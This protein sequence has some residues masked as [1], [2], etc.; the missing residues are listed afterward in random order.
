MWLRIRNKMIK[1]SSTILVRNNKDTI[2]KTINSI[3][4]FVDEIIIID[5][6]STDNTI[7]LI[8]FLTNK[9][10]IYQRKL[11]NDF[12]AQRNF[13]L[14]KCSND[15]IIVID[16][17]EEITDE[18]KENLL[19]VLKNPKY[20]AYNCQ[21]LNE[22][23]A[24]YSPSKLD[25]PILMKKDLQWKDAIHEVISEEMGFLKGDLLHHSWFGMN[26]FINDINKYSTWKAKKWISEG[27]D[28]SIG[29]LCIRQPLISLYVFF[30]RYIGEKR[31]KQGSIGFL[32]CFAWA[33][34]ELF[35]GLKY[36]EIKK[37][38]K[39]K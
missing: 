2:S 8:K 7:E 29:K 15:W 4:D 32:Y 20:L 3:N 39:D 18:L 36:Y 30:Q 9:A 16:S 38:T 27:R 10:K 37:E 11:D 22:N 19:D 12:A 25:R 33:S 23:I 17:D 24:G 14:T 26:D 31:F 34:E 21:R 5:D 13:S 1:L 35:V 28:Y 6:Y